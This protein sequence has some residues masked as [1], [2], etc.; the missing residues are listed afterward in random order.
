MHT[1]QSVLSRR[2][3]LLARVCNGARTCSWQTSSTL[4]AIYMPHAIPSARMYTQMPPSPS[5]TLRH[6]MFFRADGHPR[7][8]RAGL[9][10]RMFLL[11][12]NYFCPPP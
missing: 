5:R 4:C 2:G 6:K 11:L 1:L 7:S 12:H 9:C 10:A 8:K 3:Y